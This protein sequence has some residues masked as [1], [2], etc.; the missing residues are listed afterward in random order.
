VGRDIHLVIRLHK[1]R[2]GRDIHCIIR[3]Q[4]RRVGRDIH[5]VIRPEERRRG[6]MDK[7]VRAQRSVAHKRGRHPIPEEEGMKVRMPCSIAS[8]RRGIESEGTW[9]YYRL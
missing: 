6:G 5:R 2:V 7:M 3:L 8:W 9:L 4:K 1:R